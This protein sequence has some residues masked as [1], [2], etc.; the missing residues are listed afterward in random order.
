MR[1]PFKLNQVLKILALALFVPIRSWASVVGL[2]GL[3]QVAL[4]HV[5][6]SGTDVLLL[7]YALLITPA[8]LLLALIGQIGDWRKLRNVG[9]LIVSPWLLVPPAFGLIFADHSP[10]RF[11]SGGENIL[12]SILYTMT[13]L[14]ML[15]GVFFRKSRFGGISILYWAGLAI[16]IPFW[17][18]FE[19]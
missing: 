13:G 19:I 8:A 17:L 14:S 7:L 10:V 15:V 4:F 18:I 3:T 11:G 6:P 16:S 12:L 9:N 1:S 5:L 2:Q